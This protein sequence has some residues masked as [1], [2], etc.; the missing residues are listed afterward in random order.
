LGGKKREIV[1]LGVLEVEVGYL[2]ECEEKGDDE[3]G[4]GDGV[5]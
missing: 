4:E 3:G 1:A 5:A 2:C